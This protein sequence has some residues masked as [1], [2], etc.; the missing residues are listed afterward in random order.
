MFKRVPFVLFAILA[1]AADEPPSRILFG[2]CV[3]Q[4]KAQPVWDAIL[5]AK[6]DLF[7]M[8]GDNIYGDT[9]DMDVLRAKYKKLGAQ[10]GYQKLLKL[11]PIVA[12]WDDHDF[13]GN[14]AGA[15]YAL[16]EE[17]Q[18]I[19]LDFFGFPKDDPLRKQKGIYH[20]RTFGPPDKSVQVVMLDT[21]YHRSPLRKKAKT[22]PGDGPYEPT[23][24][25]KTTILGEEQ[26]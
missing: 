12:T 8:A 5:A 10:P 4:D 2:S 21:R 11:C 13:G 6:P 22:I 3:H 7:I 20:A 16:R 23:F 1:V 25:K 24:D 18:Q 17:S 19:F 26:W 14:D 9:K 15:N